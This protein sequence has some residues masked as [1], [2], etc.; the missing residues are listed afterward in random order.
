MIRKKSLSDELFVRKFRNLPVFSIFYLIRTRI[1][2]L[3]ELIQNEFSDEQYCASVCGCSPRGRGASSPRLG[4]GYAER[5]RRDAWIAQRTCWWRRRCDDDA[6]RVSVATIQGH[7]QRPPSCHS[8]R[9]VGYAQ[10]SGELEAGVNIQRLAVSFL[11]RALLAQAGPKFPLSARKRAENFGGS[12]GRADE[13]ADN[14]RDGHHM[15]SISRRRSIGR[16][17]R[18]MGRGASPE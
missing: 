12:H 8:P 18:R 16:R 2:G 11:D 9:Q 3:R 6:A 1:F 4:G 17:R 15:A 5:S 14:D 10:D 13:W 7:S